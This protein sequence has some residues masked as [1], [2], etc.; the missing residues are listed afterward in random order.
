MEVADQDKPEDWFSFAENLLADDELVYFMDAKQGSYRWIKIEDNQVKAILFVTQNGT[1]PDSRDVE[2]LLGHKLDENENTSI[3]LAGMTSLGN[4]V[5]GKQICA[6]FGVG[7]NTIL[8]AIQDQQLT[9]V[10]QIG[11]YLK[12]GTNCGSCIPELNGLLKQ[13]K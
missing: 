10:A 6:C 2:P 1:L 5:G 13:E 11:D 7:E 8:S 3:L 4:D 12:A 9:D